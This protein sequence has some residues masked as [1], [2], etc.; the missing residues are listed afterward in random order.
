MTLPVRLLAC[1]SIIEKLS[2]IFLA[3]VITVGLLLQVIQYINFI[4]QWGDER[5]EMV[6]A[7]GVTFIWFNAGD[8]RNTLRIWVVLGIYNG[9]K[10]LNDKLVGQVRKMSQDLLGER[11]IEVED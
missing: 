6:Q 9:V 1:N 5:R 10:N 11:I 3:G 7:V 4:R 2:K 8:L